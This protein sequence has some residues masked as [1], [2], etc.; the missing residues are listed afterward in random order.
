MDT[1]KCSNCGEQK[2]ADQFHKS[3]KPRGRAYNCKECMKAYHKDWYSRNAPTVREKDAKRYKAWRAESPNA[4]A[5][6]RYGVPVEELDALYDAFSE[7]MICG[8]PPVRDKRLCVDHCHET[9]R[10]RGLLCV[11]CN[12]A[13]GHMDDDPGR[14][15]AAADYLEE[16]R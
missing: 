3:Q 12:A 9:N 4:Q 13:L 11:K 2:P 6:Y 7:C 5:A 8:G 1:L 10:V 14:L 16:A 15:R